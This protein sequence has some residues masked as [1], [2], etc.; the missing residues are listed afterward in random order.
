MA[1]KTEIFRIKPSDTGVIH[2]AER[3][4]P[5]ALGEL[6]KRTRVI[7]EL[8]LTQYRKDVDHLAMLSP[9]AS[10]FRPMMELSAR[11]W[12]SI[13]DVDLSGKTVFMRAEMNVPKKDG[14]ISDYSRL[15]PVADTIK[16]CIEKGAK[17]IYLVAHL[18]R[19]KGKVVE[20]ERLDVVA[21]ALNERYGIPV[22]KLDDCVGADVEDKFASSKARVVL[23]EN[24]RFHPEEEAK[25]LTDP[26]RVEFVKSLA[27]VIGWEEG[28][29][30]EDLVFVNAGYGLVHRA[31]ASNTGVAG[32]LPVAVMDRTVEKEV[33][34]M[35]NRL[36]NPDRPMTIALSGIKDEKGEALD[37]EL[38]LGAD[39]V[40]VG[41]G[42]APM[43]F[44]RK[45][46]AQN[47]SGLS[48]QKEGTWDTVQKMKARLGSKLIA[49]NDLILLPEGEK[50]MSKAIPV[51]MKPDSSGFVPAGTI[52]QGYRIVD[53]G[54][55]SRDKMRESVQQSKSL[56]WF[57]PLGDPRVANDTNQ[58]L[59]DAAKDSQVPIIG[60]GGDTNEMLKTLG[61]SN[62]VFLSTGGGASLHLLKFADA[63]GLSIMTP[64]EPGNQITEFFKQARG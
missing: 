17:K 53:V 63:P 46:D 6:E 32:L 48:F 13:D 34:F 50:D 20:A 55:K 3:I 9:D 27:R 2:V 47:V 39:H 12:K 28:K 11:E 33:N 58:S 38:V 40:I 49:P 37:S 35:L 8:P 36:K 24:L 60:G 22:E 5:K 56:V 31:H 15:D 7:T 19:P 64:T 45:E 18:G 1:S 43:L 42:L 26:A 59:I 16:T 62:V 29:P 41:S 54:P 44:M 30:N 4:D 52:P 23:G 21:K 25:D 10:G 57:G 61:A 51:E 14:Q